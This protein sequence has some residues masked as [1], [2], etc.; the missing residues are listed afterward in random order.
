[1]NAYSDR[2][3]KTH[4]RITWQRKTRKSKR[5]PLGSGARSSLRK[6]AGGVARKLWEWAGVY[7]GG[8]LAIVL[9]LIFCL[10]LLWK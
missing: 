4:W 8:L 5:N 2:L 3:D 1:M 10:Y 9:C 7:D 6:G